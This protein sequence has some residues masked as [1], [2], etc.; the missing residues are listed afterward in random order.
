METKI[1]EKKQEKNRPI[2]LFEKTKN[3]ADEFGLR[4]PSKETFQMVCSL[5]M[6]GSLPLIKSIELN[7]AEYLFDKGKL[8]PAKKIGQNS[9]L[10]KIYASLVLPKSYGA[11]SIILKSQI[12]HREDFTAFSADHASTYVRKQI[13]Q[14]KTENSIM[15]KYTL[16]PAEFYELYPYC[17]ASLTDHSPEEYTPHEYDRIKFLTFDIALPEIQKVDLQEVFVKESQL[18]NEDLKNQMER[19]KQKIGTMQQTYIKPSQEKQRSYSYCQIS[20]DAGN[21]LDCLIEE[22]NIPE[23]IIPACLMVA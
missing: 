3:L 21:I 7:A 13:R 5:L 20:S 18:Y 23:K 12:L 10:E 9:S 8:E 1:I 14:D 11:I 2:L 6:Q 4:E 19:I 17:I 16:N 15:Q 22:Y